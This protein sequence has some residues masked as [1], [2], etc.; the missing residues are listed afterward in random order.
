MRFFTPWSQIAP[1]RFTR[2]LPQEIV[3]V[4]SELVAERGLLHEIDGYERLEGC[5]VASCEGAPLHARCSDLGFV[6]VFL[7]CLVRTPWAALITV[8]LVHFSTGS[9]TERSVAAVATT[10]ED[11][12]FYAWSASVVKCAHLPFRGWSFGD[13]S[14][15]QAVSL[16]FA[17][18]RV[19]IQKFAFK[20][21]V[22]AWVQGN[23]TAEIR[24]AK[25]RVSRRETGV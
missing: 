17:R 4:S 5:E 13:S 20:S 8:N 12:R 9:S 22:N 1:W 6:S 2:A 15:S 23:A 16:T 7:E 11:R 19:R 24:Q 18:G 10:A 14:L 21:P 25:A 3:P